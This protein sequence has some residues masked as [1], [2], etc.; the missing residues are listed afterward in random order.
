M[1]TAGLAGIRIGTAGWRLAK[2]IQ[3]RFP[4]PGTHLQRYAARL[5]AVEINSSFYR[6]HR[7]STYERWAREA[8]DDFRFAVKMPRWLTH[9]QRLRDTDGL[10]TFLGEVAGL[11]ARQ[12][13]ILIQLPP[14]LP[15]EAETVER[16][17]GAVRRRYHGAL[18]CEPRHPSWFCETGER[19]LRRHQVARAA[20]DPPV[21]ATAGEPGGWPAP[22]YYRLHGSPE[23]FRSSYSDEYLASLSEHLGTAETSCRWCIF[24]NTGSEAGIDNGLTLQALVRKSDDAPIYES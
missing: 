19:I 2:G 24:N 3:D 9:R 13:P 22:V 17:L 20:V 14:S 10:D 21:T 8:G 16:F 12:G 5:T 11:G 4:G 18:V 7:R 23:R 6:S 1:A 15:L